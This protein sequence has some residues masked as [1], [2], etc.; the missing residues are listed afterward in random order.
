MMGIVKRGEN[1]NGPIC[2]NREMIRSNLWSLFVCMFISVINH[3]DDANAALL[4]D[5]IPR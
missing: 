5:G 4:I 3:A 2:S 1:Q